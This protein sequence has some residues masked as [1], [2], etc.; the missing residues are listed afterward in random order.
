MSTENQKMSFFQKIKSVLKEA[1][2]EF[3]RGGFRAV[4]KR[5]GWKFFAAIFCYYLVRDLTLYVFI[6]FLVMRFVEF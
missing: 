5:F 1:K 3:K 4:I 2:V 6:P